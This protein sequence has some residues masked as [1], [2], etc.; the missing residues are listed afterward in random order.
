MESRGNTIGQPSH[1]PLSL[2]FFHHVKSRQEKAL[3]EEIL[4]ENR[5]SVIVDFQCLVAHPSHLM[6]QRAEGKGYRVE[7]QGRIQREV[8]YQPF[9]IW[10]QA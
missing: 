4:N 6:L 1:Q 8:I 7:E 10:L 9:E 3:S 5:P 2:P